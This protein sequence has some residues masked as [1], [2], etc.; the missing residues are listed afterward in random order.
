LVFEK[1]VLRSRGAEASGRLPDDDG[2][3]RRMSG[4]TGDD[5]GAVVE[6]EVHWL[7]VGI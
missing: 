2:G 6:G 7:V 4:A 3:L 1:K 5:E